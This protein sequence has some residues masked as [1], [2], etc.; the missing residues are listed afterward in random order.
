MT[1]QKPWLIFL[2]AW[3][4]GDGVGVIVG[5]RWNNDPH[6]FTKEYNSHCENRG[7]S[8]PTSSPPPPH[9]FIMRY[10]N[11]VLVVLIWMLD[12]LRSTPENEIENLNRAEI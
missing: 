7:S 4:G 12:V 1:W 6:V 11:V 2:Q 8:L 5:E 3:V 10:T 9:A